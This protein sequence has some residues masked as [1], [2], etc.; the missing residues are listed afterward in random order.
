MGYSRA[1]VTRAFTVTVSDF[2][3]CATGIGLGGVE[4]NVAYTGFIL[5]IT[6]ADCIRAVGAGCAGAI[7]YLS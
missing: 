6:V 3:Q 5:A 7:A 1:T 2:S 4:T